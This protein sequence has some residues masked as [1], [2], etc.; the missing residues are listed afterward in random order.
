VIRKTLPSI[1]G[2]GTAADDGEKLGNFEDDR[3]GGEAMTT[4]EQNAT[5]TLYGFWLSPYV[6]LVAHVLEEAGLDYDYERVSPFVGATQSAAHRLRNP[7]GKVPSL[8]EP[9]GTLLYESQAICRFLARRYEGVRRF[10]PCDDAVRCARVD[11]LADFV[12][13]SISGPFFYWFVVG[14]YYPHAFHLKVEAESEIFSKLS[15]VMISGALGRLGNAGE[16]KPFL[17]GAEPTLPDFHL[18]HVLELS[19]TFSELFDMPM[20]NLLA[21]S[22]A[23]RVF[24]E[25]MASRPS[26]RTILDRQES[27]YATT[28]H[29]IL[30]EFGKTMEPVLKQGRGGLQAL[31]GHEV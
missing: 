17:L 30:E 23:L 29:E 19:R 27:E 1:L 14:A 26:S 25:A 16:M 28:R 22:P 6:S 3:P 10:Y 18:F 20:I 24:H 7:L 5:R 12:T 8:R 15:M 4:D 31:F 21:L 9:D 2:S 11:G 13:F